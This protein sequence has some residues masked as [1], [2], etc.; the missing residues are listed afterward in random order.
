MKGC[1]NFIKFIILSIAALI[2][3]FPC[4]GIN[5][6][7]GLIDSQMHPQKTTIN[8]DAQKL[9]NFSKLPK[10]YELVRTVNMLGVNAVIAQHN[11]TSQKFALVDTGWIVSINKNDIKT[12]NAVVQ[13]QDTAKKYIP[14][15][16]LNQIEVIDKGSFKALN[17]DIPYLRVKINL[18]NSK[19]KNMEGIIGVVNMPGKKDDLVLAVNEPGKYKQNITE[20]FFNSVKINKSNN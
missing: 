4:G 19:Q 17:Q 14:N 11:K 6:V 20:K 3:L 2:I 12:N 18:G 16:K 13:I 15:V 1:F 10:E 9:A 7:K 8:A 5:Y